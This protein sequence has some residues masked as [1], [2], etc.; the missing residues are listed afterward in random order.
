[1]LHLQVWVMLWGK[2]W[3]HKAFSFRKNANITKEARGKVIYDIFFTRICFQPR[4]N[5]AT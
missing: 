2:S 5:V 3:K 1:M 4:S